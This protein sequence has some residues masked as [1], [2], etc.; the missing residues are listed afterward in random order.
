MPFW[1]AVLRKILPPPTSLCDGRLRWGHRFFRV[2][3]P[4]SLSGFC[5]PLLLFSSSFFTLLFSLRVCFVRWAKRD[6]RIRVRWTNS[7]GKRYQPG[8]VY[9]ML[10]VYD[11]NSIK[12]LSG[13]VCLFP[14]L[15]SDGLVIQFCI[16]LAL[17]LSFFA[18][19]FLY[20][21]VI[22]LALVLSM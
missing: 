22:L 10:Y 11:S 6:P 7:D 9:D 20:R 18:D 5:T 16:V 15:R 14:L 12:G 13:L 2:C 4:Y 3:K 21:F 1:W 19:L 17:L 8:I